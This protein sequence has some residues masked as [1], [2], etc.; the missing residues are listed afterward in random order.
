M[1]FRS[2]VLGATVGVIGTLAA[3][4]IIKE[5]LGLGESLAGRLLIYDGLGGRFET[6]TFA[7]DPANPLTG[8]APSIHDLADVPA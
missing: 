1:L 4:E 6:V 8:T 5:I 7:W 2:G 3:C